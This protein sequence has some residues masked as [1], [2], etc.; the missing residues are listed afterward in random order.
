MSSLATITQ[1]IVESLSE[2]D[3]VTG[4]LCFGSYALETYDQHSDIDLYVLCHPDILPDRIRRDTFTSSTKA[5]KVMIGCHTPGWDNQ[6]SPVSD[7]ITLGQID[8]DISYNTQTWLATVVN[9]VVQEGA[10]SIP[11]LKFRAYTMLGLLA[12]AIVLYEHQRWITQLKANL[13]PYPARL[14]ANLIEQNN[15][16]LVDRLQELEDCAKRDIGHTMFLFHLWQACDALITILFAINNFYDPATKRP[17]REFG[18]L[19]KIP[20]NFTERYQQ[21]LE[22]PFDKDGR[23]QMVR[24]LRGLTTE[25]TQFLT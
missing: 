8:F 6:W 20:A 10:V 22:G 19:E 7:N 15:T 12:N 23:Q 4:I 13:F 1:P 18:K 24:L 5:T 25:V 21:I 16:I 3:E 9:K 14:K 11:E 17:E 2:L